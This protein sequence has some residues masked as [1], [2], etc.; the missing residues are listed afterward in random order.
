MASSSDPE[1]VRKR[2]MADPDVQ[3]ILK[4]P[5][6]RLILEQMQEDPRALQEYITHYFYLTLI[7]TRFLKNLCSHLQ[8]LEESRCCCQNPEAFR[9]WSD[10][11]P[12]ILISDR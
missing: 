10:C 5:A 4:D 9:V 2:A 1:E 12:L 3:G 11:Y 8:A 6:M 7:R